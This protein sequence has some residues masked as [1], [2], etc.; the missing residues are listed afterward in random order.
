M[1]FEGLLKGFVLATVGLLGPVS[2]VIVT[3]SQLRRTPRWLKV[4]WEEDGSR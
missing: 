1:P 3:C 2:Q 4:I